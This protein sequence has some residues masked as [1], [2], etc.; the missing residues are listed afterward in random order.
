MQRIL[1]YL[2]MVVLPF[3][4]MGN[5]CAAQLKNG[6]RNPFDKNIWYK[7]Y[8][9]TVDG[10]PVNVN[11]VLWNNY[12][13]GSFNF[14]NKSEIAEITT[15]KKD[16]VIGQEMTL[17]GFVRNEQFTDSGSKSKVIITKEGIHGIWESADAKNH[18]NISLKEEYPEGS[19]RFDLLIHRDSIVME[20]N[21]S[22][23][24]SSYKI[25][26]PGAKM[27]KDEAAWFEQAMV[28]CL[29]NDKTNARNLNEYMKSK[30]S[31]EFAAY[32]K[33]IEDSLGSEENFY[34]TLV[35][36]PWFN[37]N[38][39]VVIKADY[40]V[41][42]PKGHTRESYY[43][44]DMLH[45]KILHLSDIMDVDTARLESLL[46][47]DMKNFYAPIHPD[48]GGPFAAVSNDIYVSDYGI[49]FLFGNNDFFNTP[50][51]FL[52]YAKV[53]DMLKPEFKKRMKL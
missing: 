27:R 38:G 46:E 21:H 40:Y 49:T 32:K 20:D 6:W 53:K 44:L 3:V 7:R 12:L 28:E 14:C 34:L 4:F 22:V 45:K 26:V 24:Y 17:Y 35:A 16:T 23:M 25:P 52:P 15:H 36:A 30:D 10:K 39:I 2:L 37:N 29:D 1:R 51:F 47:K 9:G 50:C 33:L 42:I 41:A 8:S 18:A 11:L 13:G 48:F 19:Y 5:Y 43:C 31:L